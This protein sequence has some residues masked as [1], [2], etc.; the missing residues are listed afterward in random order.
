MDG[1]GE[2]RR[3]RG[4]APAPR[5]AAVWLGLI[6]GLAWFTAGVANDE[7]L[8]RVGLYTLTGTVM[9]ASFGYQSATYFRDAKWRIGRYFW[10]FGL[11]VLIPMVLVVVVLEVTGVL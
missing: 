4:P 5:Q 11:Y 9:G 6:L 2:D 7:S 8:V 10:G 1:T 3:H